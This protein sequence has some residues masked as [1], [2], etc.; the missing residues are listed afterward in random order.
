MGAITDEQ[1]AT[2]RADF[3]ADAS[4]KVAQ[5]AVTGNDV[6]EVALDRDL[7]ASTHHTFS[8]KLDSWK[9]TNQRA[10]GR[11]WLFAMLNQFRVG[12]MEKMGLKQFE[13]SQ[14]HIHF[15]DKFERANH[16]LNA[17]I[18]LADR[19]V[20]DRTVAFLLNGPID[21]G[22][23]WNMAV[24]LVM[25]HGLVPK[26]AYPESKSSSSTRRM[27]QS[28]LHLLRA[29]AA[30]LREMAA[31]GAG[32]ETLD[33]HKAARMNDV[34]RILCIHLGTPPETFD[35]QWRDK[36]DNFHR[37]G[38]MTPQQFVEKFVTVDI[39]D[40]VCLVHDP[41][42]PTMQTYTVEWLNNV[43][44]G[45][46]VIYL[47]IGIEEMKDITRR[48]LEDGET[49]WMGCDVG[50]QMHRQR[51]LWDANLF[52]FEELY[53]I[54]FGLDKAARLRHHQ[55][56]MTHAMLFTGVDVVEGQT[57]RWRV[58]NSW[59]DEKSGVKGYYT[60]ND[61]WFDEYM[62]EIAAPSKY[63]SEEMRAALDTTPV[64]LPPWDPMGSLAR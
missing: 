20:D 50:K 54:E 38:E 41:R 6:L 55:T 11:C 7:V 58:E 60:M 15:W 35:W 61:N 24:N 14:A 53:G 12:T 42:N 52:Q 5:N 18:E 27:N 51:G 13:F 31:M 44:D 46:P 32:R 45:P 48:M 9:V 29:S 47:N 2:L 16:F 21:D 64:A 10:S 19:P 40:F 33:A 17:M 49:V 25:K 8:T 57:R 3:D 28:L 59:G 56:L 22:G 4:A 43:V 23:Q 37:E 36:D 62:F 26:S 30:E 63:L 1:I 34:W 39:E